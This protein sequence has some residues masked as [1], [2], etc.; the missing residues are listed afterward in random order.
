MASVDEQEVKVEVRGRLVGERMAA[1][2]E[3]GKEVPLC[4]ST[5]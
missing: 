1:D 5:A 3:I 2:E 4:L